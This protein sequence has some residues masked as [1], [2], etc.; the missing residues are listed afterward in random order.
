MMVRMAKLV[1]KNAIV[2]QKKQSFTVCIESS[3]RIDIWNIYK[4]F[5]CWVFFVWAE[6]ADDA[7]RFVKKNK[8]SHIIIFRSC[9]TVGKVSESKERIY[10]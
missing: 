7:I 8:C 2:C 6:L 4:I 9:M 3:C 10:V 5:K 1:L